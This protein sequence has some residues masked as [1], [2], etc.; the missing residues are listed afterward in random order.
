[1]K[2]LI[3]FQDYEQE[4]YNFLKITIPYDATI[5]SQLNV[6]T[7]DYSADSKL[8]SY[9]CLNINYQLMALQY[10][11]L[12]SVDK[13]D[14]LTTILETYGIDISGEY[15][16]E[17]VQ[18]LNYKQNFTGT[19]EQMNVLNRDALNNYNQYYSM[20]PKPTINLVTES[21]YLDDLERTK[22]CSSKLEYVVE[23]FQE[24]DFD[25]N[26]QVLFNDEL[27]ITGP[28]KEIMWT[29]QPKTFLYGLSPYGKVYTTYNF[30]KFF[31]ASAPLA[32][33]VILPDSNNKRSSNET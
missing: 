6:L 19:T 14:I 13:N 30:D 25:I 11:A 12:V 32:S 29:T 17:L 22:F 28:V 2:N 24:N 7:F 21:V 31:I 3:Y 20:V 4:Y 33:T 23:L 9:E 15:V 5:N 18:W 8:I 27:S 10:P 16:M 26:N 1:L